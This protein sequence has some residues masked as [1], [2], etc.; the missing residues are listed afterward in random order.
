MSFDMIFQ[1]IYE[2]IFIGLTLMLSGCTHVYVWIPN[3]VS[4]NLSNVW[5]ISHAFDCSVG[6][7]ANEEKRVEENG[8]H[9]TLFFKNGNVC[10][11]ACMKGWDSWQWGEEKNVRK[12]F[13]ILK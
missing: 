3:E 8:K 10:L 13:P 5:S 4:G 6:A 11:G 1:S 9:N 2:I 12:R 7:R